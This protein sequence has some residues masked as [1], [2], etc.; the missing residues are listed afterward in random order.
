MMMTRKTRRNRAKI[1]SDSSDSVPLHCQTLPRVNTGVYAT[2]S[3]QLLRL[4]VCAYPY[5]W[6]MPSGK[7]MCHRSTNEEI[8]A[9]GY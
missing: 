6:E 8:Q 3:W 7:M 4:D 1:L 2:D 9:Q 5:S